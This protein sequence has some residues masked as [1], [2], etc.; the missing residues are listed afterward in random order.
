M[1]KYM[2]AFSLRYCIIIHLLKH[3]AEMESSIFQM[4]VMNTFPF[5]PFFDFPPQVRRVR[6]CN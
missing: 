4:E 3:H 1:Y 2:Q 5:P 6:L